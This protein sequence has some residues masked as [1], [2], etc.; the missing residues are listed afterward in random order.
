MS[1]WHCLQCQGGTDACKFCATENIPSPHEWLHL[2][3]AHMSCAWPD[4]M[5]CRRRAQGAHGRNPGRRSRA[6]GGRPQPRRARA[7]IGW[8]RRR[9]RRQQRR[10]TGRARGARLRQRRRRRRG[11]HRRARRGARLDQGL[12]RALAGARAAAGRASR[13]CKALTQRNMCGLIGILFFGQSG[14]GTSAPPALFFSLCCCARRARR[15]LRRRPVLSLYFCP[16][17]SRCSE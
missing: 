3:L 10:G 15:L 12:A 6:G 2:H 17:T 16:G 14:F 8:G 1:C 11:R 5:V 7:R 9:T 4:L 13:Q